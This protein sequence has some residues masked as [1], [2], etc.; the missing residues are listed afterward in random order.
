LNPIIENETPR[1]TEESGPWPFVTR[2]IF[3]WADASTWVWSSRHHRKQLN[4]SPHEVPQLPSHAVLQSIWLP[5]KLNWWI[6][7]AFSTGSL[8]FLT[9]SILSLFLLSGMA[10]VLDLLQTNRLFFF[11][12]IFFTFAAYL[13]LYQSANTNSLWTPSTAKPRKYFGWR[14]TDIGWLSS[15]LQFIGTLLFNVNTF[16]AMSSD[17]TWIQLDVRAW[18]PDLIGSLLFLASGYLAFAET[19]HSYWR[20]RFRDLSWRI[21]FSMPETTNLKIQIFSMV[22]TATGAAGFFAGAIMMLT[23]STSR[24]NSKHFENPMNPQV[25]PD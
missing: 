6:G 17:L 15:V 13:Q 18:L 8:L 12:S 24:S 22:M 1:C 5:K 4:Y 19:C 2:R 21:V 25:I 11:G 20:W 14:P 10:T 16:N 7:L 23:E 3:E 9:A